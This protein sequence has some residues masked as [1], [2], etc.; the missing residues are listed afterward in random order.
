MRVFRLRRKTYTAVTAVGRQPLQ[1]AIVD[2]RNPEYNHNP[3]KKT[4]IFLM[5]QC[6]Y[7]T[8][9]ETTTDALLSHNTS[10]LGP[11]CIRERN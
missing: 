2:P 5:S 9:D 6:R 7:V 11:A 8:Q 10:F 3:V 1:D 4:Y